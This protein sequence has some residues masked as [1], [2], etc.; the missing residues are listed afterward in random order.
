MHRLRPSLNS[1]AMRIFQQ[2][3][4]TLA[5]TPVKCSDF[6]EGFFQQP[7]LKLVTLEDVSESLWPVTNILGV[8]SYEGFLRAVLSRDDMRRESI[9]RRGC[10]SSV[11]SDDQVSPVPIDEGSRLAHVIEVSKELNFFLPSQF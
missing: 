4:S 11:A 2:N 6:H 1:R 3:T 10:H 8:V 5:R 9:L 7:H